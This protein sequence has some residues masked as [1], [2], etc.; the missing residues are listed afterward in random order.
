MRLPSQMMIAALIIIAFGGVVAAAQHVP[1]PNPVG[2]VILFAIGIAVGVG[3][4]I[5]ADWRV[6]RGRR[7]ED[8]G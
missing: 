5:V 4:I 3:G 8:G 1:D 7:K 6:R 2:A